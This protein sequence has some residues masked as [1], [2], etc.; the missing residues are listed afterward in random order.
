VHNRSEEHRFQ[1]GEK[2]VEKAPFLRG[3]FFFAGIESMQPCGHDS[4]FA[5]ARPA[6]CPG[7]KKIAGQDAKGRLQN[8]TLGGSTPELSRGTGI[9]FS[10]ASLL[11][12]AKS[13]VHS[14][15]RQNL[16]TISLRACARSLRQPI[17]PALAPERHLLKMRW[18]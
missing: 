4:R 14:R 17:S 10:W 9:A 7:L 5:Q 15:T 11:R 12:K 13:C 2:D 1:S 6:I 8:R 18:K 16:N 3:F